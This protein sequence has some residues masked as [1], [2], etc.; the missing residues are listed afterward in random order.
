[1]PMGQ[2][3][4]QES[5]HSRRVAVHEHAAAVH[6][7][8]SKMHQAAGEFFDRHDKP[9]LADQERRLADHHAQR[10]EAERDQAAALHLPDRPDRIPVPSA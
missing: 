9:E 6:D 7:Q 1:M 3:N 4:G 2:Q 5:F 8:A 10:A